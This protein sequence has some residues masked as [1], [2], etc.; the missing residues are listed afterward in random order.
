MT[1]TE[2]TDTHYSILITASKTLRDK[3]EYNPN[4]VSQ[5]S[6]F[7]NHSEKGLPCNHDPRLCNVLTTM[8]ETMARRGITATTSRHYSAWQKDSEDRRSGPRGRRRGKG[9]WEGRGGERG[10]TAPSWRSPS[11]YLWPPPPTLS[12]KAKREA[13]YGVMIKAILRGRL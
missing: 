4:D 12:I 2:A 6:L 5:Y 11:A 1:I 9:G 7:N 3:H 8:R 13:Y 10:V